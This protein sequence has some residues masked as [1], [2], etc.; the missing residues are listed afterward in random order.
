MAKRQDIEVFIDKYDPHIEGDNIKQYDTHEDWELIKNT[1]E[2]NVFTVV[3]GDNNNWYITPGKR[4][5]NRLFYIITNK[6]WSTFD[7][8]RDYKY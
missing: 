7:T 3:D 8:T 2:N 6:P 4:Y 5:V 1:N